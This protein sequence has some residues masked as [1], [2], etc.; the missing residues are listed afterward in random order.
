M[1]VCF[2][3][4]DIV[5]L[6]S[7]I[8]LL[9]FLYVH[10][11]KKNNIGKKKKKPP[12]SIMQI[13]VHMRVCLF[14]IAIAYTVVK[15]QEKKNKAKKNNHER[16]L[17]LSMVGYMSKRVFGNCSLQVTFLFVFC[18]WVL[19]SEYW[20]IFRSIGACLVSEIKRQNNCWHLEVEDFC[21]HTCLSSRKIKWQKKRSTHTQ[22]KKKTTEDKKT[23]RKFRVSIFRRNEREEQND[24]QDC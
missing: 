3:P 18:L 15:C 23:Q 2:H 20:D 14:L 24:E 9:L 21:G 19:L 17:N 16:K 5:L 11:Q 22:E 6:G 1:R 7:V 10:R 8:E 13:H 4:Y 12:T